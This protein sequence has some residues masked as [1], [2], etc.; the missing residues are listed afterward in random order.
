MARMSKDM[1]IMSR[2]ADYVRKKGDCCM[3]EIDL[4]LYIPMWKQY[5]VYR[6]YGSMF[7]DV[8]LH[9][10]AWRLRP[11]PKETITPSIAQDQ[12]SP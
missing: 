11:V 6:G 10:G 2:I 7:P 12:L 3:G 9:R 4:Q 1:G 5:V 8:E